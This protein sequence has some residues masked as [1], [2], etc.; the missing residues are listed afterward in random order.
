MLLQE[1]INRFNVILCSGSPR[2]HH[3]LNEIGIPF[4]IVKDNDFDES[5]PSTTDV[6][7]V[8]VYLAESKSGQIN[9]IEQKNNSI[10][11]TADTVVIL[12]NTI[13]NKPE[14]REEALQMLHTLSGNKHE[15]VTG[16]CLKSSSHKKSFYSL[17]EVYFRTLSNEEIIYYVDHYKPYDKAGSY[18]IQEWIGYI[19]IE[20]INGSFFNVM[21]LPVEK[22]YV[23]LDKF[24]A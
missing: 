4:T 19:G 14:D 13:I 7:Q 2:R 10:I 20:K 22:L 5:Y 8:P 24:I 9:F 18:G 17:T 21:G 3:L 1:K 16:V 15:V 6:Y 23:E 11:I 12:N